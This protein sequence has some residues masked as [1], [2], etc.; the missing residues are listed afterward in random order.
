MTHLAKNAVKPKTKLTAPSARA[1]FQRV[2]RAGTKVPP[3][4][5]PVHEAYMDF[6][7]R[8]ADLRVSLA[9]SKQ[10]GNK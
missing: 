7:E 2:Q 6:A 8:Y 4:F 3:H 1:Y 5:E 10:R 9:V